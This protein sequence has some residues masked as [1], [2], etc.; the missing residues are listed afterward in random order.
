[1]GVQ[2]RF[3]FHERKSGFG[4]R[5]EVALPP[6]VVERNIEIQR[7]THHLKIASLSFGAGQVSGPCKEHGTGKKSTLLP[8]RKKTGGPPQGRLSSYRNGSSR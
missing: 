3:S 1:M 5:W 4:P 6:A 8:L 2:N 7:K